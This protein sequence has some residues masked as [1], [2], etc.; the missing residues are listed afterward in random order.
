MNPFLISKALFLWENEEASLLNV[1]PIA[2]SNPKGA[3]LNFRKRSAQQ[4]L[5]ELQGQI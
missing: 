1:L 3:F 5:C 2:I 4:I